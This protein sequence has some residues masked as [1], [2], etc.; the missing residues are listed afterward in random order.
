MNPE[1]T[2]TPCCWNTPHER[3]YRVAFALFRVS[4]LLSI[5]GPFPRLASAI[6]AVSYVVAFSQLKGL[7]YVRRKTNAFPLILLVFACAPGLDAG[8]RTA[9]PLWPVYL[10]LVVLTFVYANAGV[11]K[12][13]ASGPA[14]ASSDTLQAYI[15]EECLFKPNAF[16]MRFAMNRRMCRVLAG[17]SLLFE[18]SFPLVLIFPALLP[19]Y[20]IAGALF[21][22]GVYL[23]MK[24]D[25]LRYWPA[26]YMVFV[27]LL[28]EKLA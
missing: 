20:A 3:A 16:G 5:G 7:S 6:A 9:T 19:L 10:A 4:L 1:L 27:A 25:F 23:T 11:T 28:V 21:H 17:F 24:V 8:L 18:L 12:V 22:I 15:L 2:T 14:W 26:N 13:L